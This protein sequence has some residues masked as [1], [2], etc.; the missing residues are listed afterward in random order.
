V[1]DTTASEKTVRRWTTGGADIAGEEGPTLGTTGTIYVATGKA[2]ASKAVRLGDAPKSYPNSVVALDPAS[3]EPKDWFTADGVGFTSSPVVFKMGERELI[4]V[5][6][7]DG[8]LYLLDSASLGGADHKTALAVSGRFSGAG[9][10]TALA[11]V[12]EGETRWILTSSTGA[13]PAGL[14]F[15]GNGPVTAGAVVAFKVAEQGG[16]LSLQPGWT[17]RNLAAPLAPVVVNGMVFAV[18]SGE[19]RPAGPMAVAQRAQRSTPAVLYLLD[20]ATGKEL[21]NSGKTITSFATG[22]LA[23]GGGQVYVVTNDGTH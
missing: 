20:A 7:D 5:T 13:P 19:H 17:S 1:L 12:E 18:A 10:G 23:A 22:G 9:A 11:T 4:S 6:A 16:S 8:R 21:W 15:A 14:T 2:P 3:L